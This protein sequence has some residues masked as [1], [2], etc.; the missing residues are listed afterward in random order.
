MLVLPVTVSVDTTGGVV[1]IAFVGTVRAF[2]LSGSGSLVGD[3]VLTG[4]T[5]IMGSNGALVGMGVEPGAGIGVVGFVGV[6]LGDST[7]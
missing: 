5:V 3:F 1:S 7:A 4:V 2:E 6:G